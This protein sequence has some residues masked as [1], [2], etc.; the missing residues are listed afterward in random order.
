MT[1]IK[2]TTTV[3]EDMKKKDH[4]HTA[5]GKVNW[6][7][8]YGSSSKKKKKMKLQYNPAIPLLGIYLKVTV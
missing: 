7:S 5:G 4:L 8:P 2:K 6:C 1:V 3:G